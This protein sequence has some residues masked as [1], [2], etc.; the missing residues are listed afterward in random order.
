[1]AKP[2]A[3][4][5]SKDVSK[6]SRAARRATDIDID[7]DKSLKNVKPPTESDNY[8]PAVLQ[9]HHGAGITKKS[10]HG[11]KANLSSKARKRQ[12]KGADRAEAIMD[13]TSTRREKSK[14]QSRQI[15]ARAKNWEDVNKK[16]EALRQK[17]PT[18]EE[19]LADEES[20]EDEV[21]APAK[22]WESDEDMD[23]ATGMSVPVVAA[24]TVPATETD[25]HDTIL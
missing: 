10:K 12:E 17:F 6:H 16:A 15:Q 4:N 13:R 25:D 22:G 5:K 18:E 7:T 3:G 21:K 11:R 2:G 23:A 9:A 8:R 19:A 24:A 20:S 1:M 14:D